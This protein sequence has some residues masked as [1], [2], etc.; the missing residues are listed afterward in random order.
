MGGHKSCFDLKKTPKN[1]F[2]LIC[3]YLSYFIGAP[4]AVAAAAA[5][6]VKTEGR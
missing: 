3:T 2:I 4:A 1:M 6:V 5:A